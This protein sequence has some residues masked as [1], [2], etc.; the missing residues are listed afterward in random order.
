VCC[1]TKPCGGSDER[2]GV[3]AAFLVGRYQGR[4]QTR[5]D[6][7]VRVVELRRRTLVVTDEMGALPEPIGEDA[8]EEFDH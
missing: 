5:H 6:Q 4:A 1:T 8:P 7:S 3:V 2:P